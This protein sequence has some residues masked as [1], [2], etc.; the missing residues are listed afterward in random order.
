[1]VQANLF[2]DVEVN[3]KDICYTPDEVAREVVEL[4]SPAGHILEPC[5]GAGVFS[6]YLPGADWC[7]IREGRDF[8]EYRNRVDWIVSNPPYSIFAK[9]LRHSF[10]VADHIVYLIPIIRCFVS[11]RIIADIKHY[12]GIRH[13]RVFKEA[14]FP[15]WTINFAI[16]AVY[17]QRG[18]SGGM[19]IS[20]SQA[21]NGINPTLKG[22]GQIGWFN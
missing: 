8:F 6:K 12:G 10:E 3:Q 22:A 2:G 18:Y 9:W 14:C 21:N 13:F 5:K 1:M 7:E 11:P 15:D 16:G 4:Y 20:F 19:D 17:F